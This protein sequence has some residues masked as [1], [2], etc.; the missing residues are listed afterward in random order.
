[1]AAGEPLPDGAEIRTARDSGA[2]LLLRDGSRVEARER[3]EL[4]TTH[5]GSD[6]T[7]HLDRGSVIVQAA[8]RRTG[9]LFLATADCR[10]A[11]TGTVFSVNA[12]VKGSRV[13]V[14]EG[15]VHVNRDNQQTVL[16]RGGQFSTSDT[17]EPLPVPEEI[18]WTHDKGLRRDI[19]ALQSSLSQVPLP[20]VRYGSHL[21]SLLPASTVFYA[22]IPN[23][24][25]YF[26]V[27]QR[28][29]R[30][31]AAENPELRAWLDGPARGIEPVFDKLRAANEYLGDEIVVFGTPQTGPMFLAETK[32][33]GLKEFLER[34]GLPPAFEPQPGIVLLSPH[35]Q[36]PAPVLDSSFSK[37][38]FYARIRDAYSRGT[39]MLF[40]ADLL[41]LPR[42]P[43]ASS[44]VGFPGR[45][46]VAAQRQVGDH[47]ET[48]AAITS[49]GPRSGIGAWLAAPSPMGALDYITPEATILLAFAVARPQGVVDELVTSP[50][51]SELTAA[52]RDLAMS[53]GGEIA[54]ALDG[55][56][57][58]VP[59]W[60]LVAE[61]YDPQRFQ[62]A[63]EK[64]IA[65]Y[66]RDSAASGK[67]LRL[68]HETAEGRTYYS[69]TW[70]DA[71]PLATAQYTFASGYLIAAPARPLLT[72]ALEARATGI[73]IA[74]S[75]AFTALLPHDPYS[76]FS[77]VL[78]QNVG[79]S[80]A[81]FAGLLNPKAASGLTHVKPLLVAAY[82][83]PD[84][85]TLASTGDLLGMSF[86]H[87]L[88]G[89]VLGMAKDALPLA[90][91]LGTSRQQ[92]PYR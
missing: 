54:L 4:S 69:L 16:H 75:P 19:S 88:T 57:L 26:A 10:V 40:C 48:R 49:E 77:A 30:E 9:H 92:V 6:L 47:M 45:Y 3:S 11:V 60:K 61:V 27:A 70:G 15:E 13:S 35:T 53:L 84:R 31:R 28:F 12:G 81:P 18:S 42:P 89:S 43:H 83:G 33:P 86:Q 58:P 37:T 2:V 74:R 71:G 76:D 90:E 52:H 38:E 51:S 22:S 5:S 24:S 63:L 32:R 65:V 39:G 66:N 59:S 56:P 91:L 62:A 14:V 7:V 80:L 29:F 46:L 20:K 1:M 79:N 85:I 50:P 36:T 34:A 68:A 8:K 17:L 73:S 23:L 21:L 82:G 64:C 72:R 78:F 25:E 41:K 67:Q 87:F 55:S 44:E